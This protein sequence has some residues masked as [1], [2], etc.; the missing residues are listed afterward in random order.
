MLCRLDSCSRSP[1]ANNS[2]RHICLLLPSSASLYHRLKS[3]LFGQ[4]SAGLQVR[5]GPCWAL[6]QRPMQ[7]FGGR[8]RPQWLSTP[9]GADGAVPSQHAEL[10]SCYAQHTVDAG[11]STGQGCL[12]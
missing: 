9:L 6:T 8:R 1:M 2:G 3:A 7:M 5:W 10:R 12:L 11:M 4:R